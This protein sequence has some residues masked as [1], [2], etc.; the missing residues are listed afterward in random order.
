MSS[1]T[2]EKSTTGAVGEGIGKIAATAGKI[3]AAGTN[4]GIKVLGEIL[5][6]ATKE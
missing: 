3:A 4:G 2:R 6:S 5:A 1:G